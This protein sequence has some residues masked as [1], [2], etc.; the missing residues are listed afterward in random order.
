[1]AILGKRRGL[2]GN[3]KP[4][5]K[6][7]DSKSEKSVPQVYIM[8]TLY[9]KA[10]SP[11]TWDLQTWLMNLDFFARFIE[12][13]WSIPGSRRMRYNVKGTPQNSTQEQKPH[14][15]DQQTSYIDSRC[16]LKQ[17]N[18]SSRFC[19]KQSNFLSIFCAIL[20]ICILKTNIH[21]SK[22]GKSANHRM[23]YIQRK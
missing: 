11:G 19:S 3:S 2:A 22:S 12:P 1:M 20:E 5:Y 6:V 13:G 10:R 23:T 15:Y 21:T 14:L 7:Y 8:W 16:C 18:I 17:N 9:V 4:I